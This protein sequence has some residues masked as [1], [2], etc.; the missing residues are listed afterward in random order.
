MTD[1]LAT[2][3]SY[4]WFRSGAG[5]SY[6]ARYLETLAGTL[7]STVE[8]ETLNFIPNQDSGSVKNNQEEK[9]R[10]GHWQTTDFMALI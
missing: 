10:R 1:F 3:T 8:T 9:K 5:I 7:C 4:Y 2:S 6:I